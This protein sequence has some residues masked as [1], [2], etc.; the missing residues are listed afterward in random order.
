MQTIYWDPDD[1]GTT[2]YE[3]WS[4]PDNV[5]FTL[6]T[7]IPVDQSGPNFD[8]NLNKYFYV[9]SVS[10]PTTWYKIRGS[11]G[12]Q[13]SPFTIA[14]QAELQVLLTCRIYGRVMGF[15]GVAVSGTAVAAHVQYATDQ[16]GQFIGPSGILSAYV[17]AYTDDNGN[18][19]ID[20]VQGGVASFEIAFINLKK[21]FPVP[22]QPTANLL[23]LI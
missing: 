5:T 17:E 9:D 11:D 14:M 21:S 12:T 6:L 1:S 20:L 22:V 13:F 4:S 19:E 7:T 2:F 8:P 23:D 10:G 15:D 16:S 3:V 18:F